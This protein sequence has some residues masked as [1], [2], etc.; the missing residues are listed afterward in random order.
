[1]T[2]EQKKEM[3][4]LFQQMQSAKASTQSNP[5]LKYVLIFL[6]LVIALLGAYIYFN[7]PSNVESKPE[8]TV[9]EQVTA[10]TQTEVSYVPKA[11]IKNPLT[12]AIEKEK[13]DVEAN[14]AQPV[15]TAKIN[16]KDTEFKLQQGESQKFE[17]GKVVMN[18]SSKIELDIKTPEKK[19]SLEIGPYVKTSSGNGVSYGVQADYERGK[20]ELSIGYDSKERE[21]VKAKYNIIKF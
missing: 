3:I 11:T 15:V 4:E 21:F 20:T 5:F 10:K 7:R 13:T 19:E 17:N 18:Q 16:G 12:G 8:K 1:M 9:Q 14:I 2:D 6:V